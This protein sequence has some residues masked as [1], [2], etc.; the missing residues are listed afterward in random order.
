LCGGSRRWWRRLR[1]A[2]GWRRHQGYTEQ[3]AVFATLLF[4]GTHIH[5]LKH[6]VAC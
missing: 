6:Y 3:K 5:I 4:C 2:Q 1:E